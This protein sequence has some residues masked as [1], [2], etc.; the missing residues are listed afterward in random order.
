MAKFELLHTREQIC[1]WL[2]ENIRDDLL[3]MH[4]VEYLDTAYEDWFIA[5]DVEK[6]NISLLGKV[7]DS[8]THDIIV[9]C[10]IQA[11]E[12]NG[13]MIALF[14]LAMEVSKKER[15]RKRREGK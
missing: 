15:E 13:I 5:H 11:D 12:I 10:D 1:E 2:R 6:Y 3:R 7:R 8:E 9:T 4:A 14:R